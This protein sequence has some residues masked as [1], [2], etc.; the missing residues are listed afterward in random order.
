MPGVELAISVLNNSTVHWHMFVLLFSITSQSAFLSALYISLYAECVLYVDVVLW[1]QALLEG[2]FCRRAVAALTKAGVRTY[3]TYNLELIEQIQTAAV[4]AG[5]PDDYADW[6]KVPLLPEDNLPPFGLDYKPRCLMPEAV[7]GLGELSTPT[8]T[9]HCK[10]TDCCGV[11][12][13]SGV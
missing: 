5:A 6:V 1:M 7:A 12:V 9:S 2:W 3:N 10:C 13:R 4:A 8:S 11:H